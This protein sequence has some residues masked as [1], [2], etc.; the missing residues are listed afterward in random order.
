MV[1]RNIKKQISRQVAT[2]GRLTRGT[3]SHFILQ[4][5]PFKNS[6]SDTETDLERK[7]VYHKKETKETAYSF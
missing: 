1:C 5:T 3:M 4:E 7:K 6:V 2:N